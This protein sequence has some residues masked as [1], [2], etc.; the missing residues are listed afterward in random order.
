MDPRELDTILSSVEDPL[1]LDA[2]QDELND[3]DMPLSDIADDIDLALGT[4]DLTDEELNAFMERVSSSQSPQDR[5]DAYRDMFFLEKPGQPLPASRQKY[6]DMLKANKSMDQVLEQVTFDKKAKQLA[7]AQRKEL[8]ER[9]NTLQRARAAHGAKMVKKAKAKEDMERSLIPDEFTN[10]P[11]CYTCGG[12]IELAKGF[13]CC[14]VCQFFAGWKVGETTAY[15][16]QSASGI[17][18]K[19]R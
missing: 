1:I 10:L 13:R 11:P 2:I 12:P 14:T 15:C 8:E 3:K 18:T 5:L 17:R 4:G 7:R 16:S 6:M 9:L 19:A